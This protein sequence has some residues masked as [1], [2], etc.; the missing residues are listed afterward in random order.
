MSTQS[1]ARTAAAI[2]VFVLIE[3]SGDLHIQLG[4]DMSQYNACNKKWSLDAVCR[5]ADAVALTMHHQHNAAVAPR[6]NKK[7]TSEP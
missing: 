5:V 6:S 7:I 2:S 1:F 4:L 3:A